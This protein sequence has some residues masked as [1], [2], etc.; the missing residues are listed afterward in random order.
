LFLFDQAK[1]KRRGLKTRSIQ[2]VFL[3][4]KPAVAGITFFC[5]DTK[6]PKGQECRIASGR[7]LAPRSWLTA[8]QTALSF[9]EEQEPHLIHLI[10]TDKRSI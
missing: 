3:L 2:E 6:E 7:H 1:R 8:L 4:S 5:L 9:L 10:Y